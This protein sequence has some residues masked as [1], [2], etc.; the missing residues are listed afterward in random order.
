MSTV[1]KPITCS[2][3][4]AWEAGKPLCTLI[5]E[6]LAIAVFHLLYKYLTNISL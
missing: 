4:I 3:A 2:A 6:E 5:I 1:G